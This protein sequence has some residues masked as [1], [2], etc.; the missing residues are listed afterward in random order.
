MN[1]TN[2]VLV[3]S[4]L[5]GTMSILL[6][7][8]TMFFEKNKKHSRILLV[9]SVL[10]LASA[11]AMTEYAFWVE[12]YNLFTLV[13]SF[14]FP[15]IVFFGIWFAFLIWLFESRGERGVW[16][17]LLVLLIIVVLAAMNCMDCIKL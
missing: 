8:F 11:F 12:G 6:M 5:A 7:V 9:W 17:L 10:F 16:V 4:L 15:L 13:L 14:N 2:I 1:I 3:Y